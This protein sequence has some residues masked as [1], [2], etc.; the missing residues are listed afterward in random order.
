MRDLAGK[1]AVVTGSGSGLGL[2]MARRF[3]REDMTVVVADNRLDA[4]EAVAREIASEFGRAVAMPVDVTSRQSV[5][6]LADRVDLEL[7]GTQ[8]LVNNAGVGAPSPLLEAEEL[9]WRWVIDVNLFGVLYGVQTF[10]PR[11]LAGGR[12]AHV[13]N[14]ASLGGVIGPTFEGNRTR[15]GT[16]GPADPGPMKSYMV[17][18]HGVVALTEAL[19]GDLQGTPVGVSVLC[20]AH[21]EPSGIYE[22]SARYRPAAYGGPI[23]EDAGMAEEAAKRRLEGGR[24]VSELADRVVRAVQERHFYIF[25]HPETRVLVERRCAQLMAGFDDAASFGG[26]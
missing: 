23:P 22:N 3:A 20:P 26:E 10:V 15:A 19:G 17:S 11:M 4:A 1:V 12:E 8:L 7:G 13:V 25:T 21:H 9:G 5:V 16:G 24:D 2:A 14:T 6:A 18:K